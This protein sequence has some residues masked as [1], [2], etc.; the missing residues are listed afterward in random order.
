MAK[1]WCGSLS[2]PLSVCLCLL[3]CMSF[4]LSLFL[5]I[6]LSLSLSLSLLQCWSYRS[7]S[8]CGIPVWTARHWKRVRKGTKG[9]GDSVVLIFDLTFQN[10]FLS[11]P[12]SC[13]FWLKVNLMTATSV[14]LLRALR[15]AIPPCF[16]EIDWFIIFLLSCSFS[17][18]RIV[19]RPH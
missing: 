9:V 6:C 19:E 10:D 3:L 8:H 12:W 16:I 17:Q 2:L 4:C 1:H 5:S 18:S 13:Q 15:F 11:H 7:I 14:L